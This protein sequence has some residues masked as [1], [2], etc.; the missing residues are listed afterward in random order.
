MTRL[1]LSV[2]FLTLVY[3]LTLAS[4]DPWDLAIGALL[5]TLLLALF[6]PVTVGH[7][8]A[9]QPRLP[10]RLVAFVPFAA[11]VLLDVL[12]GTW[13]V[14][15]AILGFR[16]PRDADVV[17]IPIETRSH[18]GIAVTALVT[19]LAPGSYFIGVDWQRQ[20]MLFHFLDARDPEAI[21][22]ER[23]HFY[24]RYQRP[25]FP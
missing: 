24:A 12:V 1:V 10:A 4:L 3:A 14:A 11:R 6:R 15:L 20:V 19:T 23:A 5:A 17:A 13:Q 25:V 21:R 16:S 2:L 18:R 8:A 9:P 22:R 7:H